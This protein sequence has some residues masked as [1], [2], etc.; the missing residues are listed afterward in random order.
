VEIFDL[1]GQVAEQARLDTAADR[2]APF[3][4]A[5]KNVGAVAVDD[6]VAGG[7]DVRIDP[8]VVGDAG[9]GRTTGRVYDRV[10]GEHRADASAERREPV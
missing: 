3:H 7:V 5:A 6:W 1:A 8:A 4:R 2:K 10:R 9:N